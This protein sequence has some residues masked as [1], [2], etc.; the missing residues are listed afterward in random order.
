MDENELLLRHAERWASER[1][2]TLDAELVGDAVR[3]RAAHDGF[4]ANRWPARSVQ[5][6][7]LTRW[8][9]HGPLGVPDVPT[10]VASLDTFL[11]VLAVDGTDGERVCRT[12]CPAEG[13]QAGREEDAG[14]LS[15]SGRVRGVQVDD[16]VR[17]GDRHFAGRPARRGR[18]QR[19][20]RADRRGLECVAN[21]GAAAPITR[22]GCAGQPNG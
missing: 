5:H 8:P 4:A 21:R 12:R 9:S 11:E 13:S 2:R 10:L 7:M 6:L 18:P 19:T 15:G 16:G 22:P 3:L 1:Q 17:C 20:I 14:S